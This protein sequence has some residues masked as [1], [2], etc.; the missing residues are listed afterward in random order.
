MKKLV[1]M[2]LFL[3]LFVV[4][5]EQIDTSSNRIIIEQRDQDCVQRIS[6]NPD[7]IKLLMGMLMGDSEKM[8]NV[9]N[10]L[11][12][13]PAMQQMMRDAQN[14]MREEGGHMQNGMHHQRQEQGM[15]NDRMQRPQSDTTGTRN[16]M[17]ME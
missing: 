2:F 4:A 8:R 5:Q 9:R 16:N 1:F 10:Q 11:R 12:N 3:P 15:Q 13:D 14:R 6:E 7:A 17:N